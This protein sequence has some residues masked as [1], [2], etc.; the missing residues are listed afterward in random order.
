M[1]SLLRI[2]TA[3]YSKLPPYMNDIFTL[4]HRAVKSD[5]EAV[6]LQAI[7][8]WCTV[9]EEEISIERVRQSSHRVS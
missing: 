5:E 8:F 4:T 9:C 3:Y 2:A 6:A 1:F 7:E